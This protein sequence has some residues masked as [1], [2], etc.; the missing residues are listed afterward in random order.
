MSLSNGFRLVLVV[1]TL[2]LMLTGCK[3]D[4]G[5]GVGDEQ[6]T[7]SKNPEM[8]Q[9]TAERAG[10]PRCPSNNA[11]RIYKKKDGMSCCESIPTPWLCCECS[12]SS[13]I[14][15]LIDS[16][17]D[18][19]DLKNKPLKWSGL[20]I[21]S[22]GTVSGMVN[23]ASSASTKEL[24]C[25][26][27]CD[28]DDT[29]FCWIQNRASVGDR[30]ISGINVL[31]ELLSKKESIDKSKI[32]RAFSVDTDDCDRGDTSY[33]K[34]VYRNE[35]RFCSVKA[36]IMGLR[37]GLEVELFMPE[38]LTFNLNQ[39]SDEELEVD[40]EVAE[41]SLFLGLPNSIHS[42]F[43]GY[44]SKISKNDNGTYLEMDK[45]CIKIEN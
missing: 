3:I 40:F 17:V 20:Q 38:L 35:G 42:S 31:A 1:S 22:N 36:E 9:C 6:G 23:D 5:V 27:E 2:S 14:N 39:T 24:N 13:S 41:Q 29:P 21:A 12:G 8:C 19:F 45:G 28:G 11:P 33:E 15:N 32:M 37:E 30:A 7:D 16:V 10:L 44:V 26:D 18:I 43:G 25:S 4:I 34:G